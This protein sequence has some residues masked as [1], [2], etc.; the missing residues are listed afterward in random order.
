VNPPVVCVLNS[1]TLSAGGALN[2]T[3]T[4][5]GPPSYTATGLNLVVYPLA[6]S[7]YSLAASD[8]T[9]SNTSTVFLNANPNP[10]IGITVSS[11]TVCSQETV[12][13]AGTG[14]SNANSYTWVTSGGANLTGQNITH[15]P[16]LT[17]SYSVVGSNSLGCTSNANLTVLVYPKPTL[18]ASTNKIL[19]C[20]GGGATL[21]P[22]GAN[23]YT[24]GSNVTSQTGASAV[25]NPTAT[26]SSQVIYTVQG[27]STLTGCSNTQ[28]IS[29]NVF[30]P[31]L[32]VS[33]TTI[34]CSGNSVSLNA[35]GGILATYNWDNGD[36]V[37]YPPFSSI[38]PTI[39]SPS[40][41]TVTANSVT[42]QPISLTCPASQTIAV[43][44]YSNPTITAVTEK[45]IVCVNESAKITASGGNTYKW[46][47]NASGATIT[48]APHT[49]ANNFTVTGTTTNGCK[50]TAT[51]NVEGSE[52][53]GISKLTAVIKS[54]SV[55]PNPN[56]GDFTIETTSAITLN[57]VNTLGQL[58]K[59]ISLTENNNYKESLTNM[60]IGVYF[61]SEQ[62]NSGFVTQKI[63]VSK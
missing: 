56:N 60:A 18:V 63:I 6:P 8:G 59:I 26:T 33:G 32:T 40:V 43:A 25:V 5:P 38:S 22:F 14:A 48:V 10:T 34:A 62:N 46:S 31:T 17:T 16:S 39:T 11:H 58:I 2:Y 45:T 42:T 52:C 57:L 55:Y 13:V 44:I 30:I 4:V 41:F 47:T 23:S 9:C 7:V 51:I 27:T 29:V 37:L 19:V 12:V 1:A 15:S 53:T 54:V 21:T 3:W 35:S 50:A 24:W 36:G 28:T 61:I 49:G 20:N